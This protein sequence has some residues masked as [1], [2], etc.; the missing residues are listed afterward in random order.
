MATD[1]E[2][3]A[4]GLYAVPK[5][6]YLQNEFQLPTNEVVEEE[7]ESFGIPQTQAFTNSGGGNFSG[8]NFS[9]TGFQQA[10]DARQDR[11][12]DI[13]TS[14]FMGKAKDFINPQSAKDI[15][16]S[17]YQEPRFQP[18]IMATIMGKMD[19]YRNLRGVDQA[20]I[21]QNMGYKGPTIFGE[22][23]SGLSKDPFGINIRSA[24]GNYAEYV[25]NLYEKDKKKVYDPKTQAFLFRRKE[26]NDKK[27]GELM[28]LQKQQEDQA[29]QEINPTGPSNAPGGTAG[30]RRDR[31]TKDGGMTYDNSSG[32]FRNAG[33]SNV[34]QDFNTTSASLDNYDASALY[35]KGGRAGYFF[36]G[37]V[38]YKA[39]G[40]TDAGPNRTTASKAGVGQINESGQKVSGGNYNNG[41]GN[42][43]PPPVFYDDK[44]KIITTD[45]ISKKPNLTVDYTDPKN[46]ASLKGKIG[47]NNI[48]DNDDITAEGNVTGKVGPV[49]YD[50]SFTDKGITGTN[51]TAGKFNANLNPDMQV[52]NI[53]YNNNINGINYGVNTDFDNTMFTAGVDFKNGGLASIL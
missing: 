11:L 7:T 36:G 21:A 6:K 33:G 46:Y 27:Y 42:D 48:L 32:D 22:N 13:D 24:F 38:N 3:R 2:I 45:F 40:R 9:N 1:A 8:A 49:S 18:G 19:N 14:T 47:F 29:K 16:A 53:G 43:N 52:Q 5:N 20:F 41:G 10:V 15:M 17:G 12:N 4:A 44:Q 23:T 51:L 28:G 25:K 35:A 50:T 26:F 37:R 34:S 39:G 31:F 30:G